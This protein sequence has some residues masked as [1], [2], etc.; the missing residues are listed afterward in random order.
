MSIPQGL[1]LEGNGDASAPAQVEII[2]DEIA[3]H[4]RVRPAAAVEVHQ[5]G[6]LIVVH[7]NDLSQRHRSRAVEVDSGVRCVAIS[8]DQ[9]SAESVSRCEIGTW[10]PD[11]RSLTLHCAS[12]TFPLSMEGAFSTAGGADPSQLSEVDGK[13]STP[14]IGLPELPARTK[15]LP[16]A[17]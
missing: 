4:I 2:D 14:V 15:P 16:E 8:K 3:D 12:R 1:L 10:G 9:Q 17:K 5:S 7:L 13:P 11:I 6:V